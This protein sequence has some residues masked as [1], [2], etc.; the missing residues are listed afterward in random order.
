MK[1]S[2]DCKKRSQKLIP[3]ITTCQNTF[4]SLVFVLVSIYILKP[5]KLFIVK[6][7]IYS[8]ITECFVRAV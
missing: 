8:I 4:V 5:I 6:I 2:H 3:K 1:F 7:K